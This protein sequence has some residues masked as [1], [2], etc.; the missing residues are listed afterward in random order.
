MEPLKNRPE[1]RCEVHTAIGW[2]VGHCKVEHGSGT[3]DVQVGHRRTVVA[4]AF[5]VSPRELYLDPSV[6]HGLLR[7]LEGKSETIVFLLL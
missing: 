7:G 5:V 4:Q 2:N 6:V 3:G 1:H